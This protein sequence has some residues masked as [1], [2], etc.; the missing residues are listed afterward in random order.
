[1]AEQ[2]LS[3]AQR[4]EV[5]QA[6]DQELERIKTQAGKDERSWL[7][8]N[9]WW[10]LAAIPAAAVLIVASSFRF[11]HIYQPNHFTDALAVPAGETTSFDREFVTEEYTF[12][13]AASVE[14]FALQKLAPGQIP[15]FQPTADVELWAVALKW[16]AAPETTLS[17]CRTWLKDTAGVEYGNY[18]ALI[19]DKKFDQ[20]FDSNFACVPPKTPGPN[21]PSMFEPNPTVDPAAMRPEEWNKVI[22]FA[23]PPGVTPD[24]VHIGWEPPFRIDLELPEPGHDLV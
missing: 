9:K 6:V 23:L 1:M 19:G 17:Y 24:S 16:K 13:R 22:V 21:A 11:V 7:R 14:A 15:D 8:R 5:E 4:W 12:R 10:C 20:N 3:D 2:E 18:S